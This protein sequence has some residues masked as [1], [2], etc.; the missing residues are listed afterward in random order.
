MCLTAMPMALTLQQQ[1]QAETHRG[2][3]PK[4]DSQG[5]GKAT[6]PLF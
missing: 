1:A 2:I 6:H 5:Y 3:L 4:F